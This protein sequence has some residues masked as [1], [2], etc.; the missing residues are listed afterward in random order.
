MPINL[1]TNKQ[2]LFS[3]ID[4]GTIPQTVEQTMNGVRQ[5]M[6]DF[7]NFRKSLG[8]FTDEEKQLAEQQS[9]Q[10]EKEQKEKEQKERLANLEANMQASQQ[11]FNDQGL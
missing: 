11:R 6:S 8:I 7:T 10:R 2:P 4:Y 3:K 1:T 5:T 9:R